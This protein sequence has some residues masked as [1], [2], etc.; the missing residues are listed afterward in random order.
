MAKSTM[1]FGELLRRLRSAAALSQE[2]LAERAGLSRNGVSDLER[3]LHPTPRLETVRLLAEALVLTEENRAAL[4]AAARPATP[5]D[6]SPSPGAFAATPLPMPLTRLI[7][8]ET[9]LAALQALLDHDDVRLLTVTGAGGTGKTRLA[10][11]TAA[12]T[13]DRYADGV[14]I[15]DLAPLLDPL[16]VLPSIAATLDVRETAEEPLLITL[17]RALGFRR[18]LLVLDNCERVLMAAPEIATL[19]A[20][21]PGTTV[22]ATSRQRLRVRG[23]REFPLVPL[24]LPETNQL[25]PPTELALIPAITLFVERA[26]EVQPDFGLTVDN[27]DAVVAICRRLDGLPLAIELAAARVKT[28]PPAALLARLEPRLPLLTG[29]G[30][31]LPARQRTMRDTIAWSYDLL[32]RDDQTLFRRLSIFAGGCTQ[33][34][35]ER[36][37]GDGQRQAVLIGVLGLVEQNLLRQ[38]AEDDA[39]PRYQM[40]E[41]VR[42][43]G[44]EQLGVAGEHETVV[45][46]HADWSVAF[47][48]RVQRHGGLSQGRGL[49]AVEAEH[50]NLRLAL[51]WL[52]DHGATITALHLAGILAE[53]WLRHGYVGE[54]VATVERVLAADRGPPTAARVEALVGLNMMLWLRN[55]Y[56]RSFQLL[57][58]AEAIA[59]AIDD[60]W[61]RAYA[62]LHQGYT[63]FLRSDLD[64]AEAR[65]EEAASAFAAMGNAI[66]LDGALWLLALIALKQGEFDLAEVR[67]ARLLTEAARWNDEISN[68][69]GYIGLAFLAGHRGDY[70]QALACNAVAALASQSFGDAWATSH[71]LDGTASAAVPLGWPEA[72]VRLFGAADALRQKVHAAPVPAFFIDLAGHACAMHT[73]REALGPQRFRAAWEA[74]AAL[75]LEAA[76]AEALALAQ[77]DTND[78]NRSLSEQCRAGAAAR[79]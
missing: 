6:G 69:N 8:R 3:G 14:A 4:L 47:I 21:C 46:R 43:F 25:L 37:A 40:L 27:A 19:L 53:F 54:G 42:E 28:L 78:A 23:E 65:G 29:G 52:L 58:E 75:S 22:L 39:E 72:A 17:C 10:L 35:A 67:Y 9:E 33:E 71:G 63:A 60:E 32:S 56:D 20:A 48:E 44:L 50:P 51:D 16:L 24:L 64:F 11:E 41:T 15:V 30:H 79:S 38:V 45:Q 66:H 13:R 1:S 36:V 5:D 12:T 55:E 7:G 73:A 62:R 2:A 18:L 61:A 76:V 70:R 31:D 59:A 34:A 57:I 49:A 74:G 77:P 68:F 26:T